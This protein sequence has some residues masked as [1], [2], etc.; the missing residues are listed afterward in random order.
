MCFSPAPREGR[1]DL[2]VL[3]TLVKNKDDLIAVQPV[4]REFSPA[5]AYT[6]TTSPIIQAP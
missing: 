2:Q 6:S 1:I 4:L 3:D 5:F